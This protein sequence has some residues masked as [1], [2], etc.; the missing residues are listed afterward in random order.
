MVEWSAQE[1]S[2]ISGIFS[3]LDYNDI[4]AK[5]LQRYETE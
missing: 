1:R 5:A 3:K 2:I 4:G